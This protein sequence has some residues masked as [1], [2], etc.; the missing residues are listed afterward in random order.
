M[1]KKTSVSV[2]S[3]DRNAFL[4]RGQRRKSRLVPADRKTTV[5]QLIT[6][7]SWGELK[8]KHNTLNLKGDKL[9]YN[10]RP[11]Q[12]P[13]LSNLYRKLGLQW[14]QVYNNWTFWKNVA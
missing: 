6:L 11:Y 4:I 9:L 3:A 1:E 10:N 12:V 13:L 2:S 5:T 8:S 14:A 7:Y